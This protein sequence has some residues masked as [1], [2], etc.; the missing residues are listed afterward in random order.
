MNHI[1]CGDEK[2]EYSLIRKNKKT[3]S[4]T[5]RPNGAV[6]VSAPIKATIADIE[7]IMYKRIKWIWRKLTQVQSNMTVVRE[8]EYISGESFMYLGKNYKLKVIHAENVR[9][10]KI[11]LYRGMLEVSMPIGIEESQIE[12]KSEI[13]KWYKVQAMKKIE[14]RIKLYTSKTKLLPN[15]VRVKELKTSWGICTSK[16]NL[17][18]NWIIIMAPLSVLDYVVIHE[19]C[20]LKHHNH[21]KE[22]WSM[23]GVYMPEYRAK[24]EWLKMNGRSLVV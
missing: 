19:L 21:G 22:F 17:T 16:G 11:K 2:I 7:K 24:K 23:V 8:K 1:N 9:T 18:L 6:I 3:L 14:E 15:L 13:E 10:I 20:H 5:I 12:I 4:I